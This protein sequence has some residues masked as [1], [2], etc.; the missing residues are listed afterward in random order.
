MIDSLNAA[1]MTIYSL[2]M[3]PTPCIRVAGGI[4]S[5]RPKYSCVRALTYLL[6]YLLDTNYT[7]NNQ[8][9]GDWPV[10]PLPGFSANDLSSVP[11]PLVSPKILINV[12]YGYYFTAASCGLRCYCTPLVSYD[13]MA[14]GS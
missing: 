9:F 2:V 11:L 13:V 7:Q 10:I 6:T 5:I 4:I 14:C 8:C 12:L 1:K 3:T